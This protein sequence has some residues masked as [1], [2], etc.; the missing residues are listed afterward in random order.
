MGAS[1]PSGRIPR[2]Y[3]EVEWVGT[4]GQQ[5]IPNAVIDTGWAP[6]A[7]P[8]MVTK[9]MLLATGSRS[10]FGISSTNVTPI[11]VLYSASTTGYYKWGGGGSGTYTNIETWTWLDVEAGKQLKIN[12]IVKSTGADT[13]WSENTNT[14]K[15]FHGFSPQAQSRYKE[16]LL[17]EEQALVRDLIPCYRKADN[18][19]GFYCLVTN[20][21]YTCAGSADT[22]TKGAD[23]S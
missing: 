1:I 20:Q 11:W 17:Y 12:G 14:L 7:T 23:V 15:L 6:K 4:N 8:K 21:F 2:N 3:K 10:M 9:I 16:I 22:L 5:T 19:C 18:R 13:K